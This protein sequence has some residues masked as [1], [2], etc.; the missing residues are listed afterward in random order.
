MSLAVTASVVSIG[1]GINS[2]MQSRRGGGGGGGGGGNADPFAD[3]RG[4]YGDIINSLFGRRPR[5]DA[6]GQPVMG[7]DGN[8]VF[9]TA[10]PDWMNPGEGMNMGANIQALAGQGLPVGGEG[11]SGIVN[12][13]PVAGQGMADA[14][15]LNP[16]EADIINDPVRAAQMRTMT[17]AVNN[18]AAAT[19]QL[20]SGSTLAALQENA[21]NITASA[22]D[23]LYGRNLSRFQAI[24]NAQNQG[25]G[26]G[27]NNAGFRLGAQGQNFSQLFNTQ[28]ANFGQNLA[29][30]SFTNAAQGQRNTQGN[31]YANFLAMLAGANVNPAQAAGVNNAGA[32]SRFGM[33]RDAFGDI[34]SG[35]RGLRGNLN[36]AGGGGGSPGVDVTN[37]NFGMGP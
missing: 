1:S 35:F 12:G 18:A 37:P 8:P 31:N 10:L 13:L 23:R 19:G 7:P 5:L 11:I 14:A 32:A 22:G 30:G 3:S 36:F 15:M 4:Q 27:F 24:N 9:D 33:Q 20:D 6:N 25:F 29:A 17:N 21:G 2:I 28:G 16:T 34:I 26:Q